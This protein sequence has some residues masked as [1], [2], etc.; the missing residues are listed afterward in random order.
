MAVGEIWCTLG[1]LIRRYLETVLGAGN[2]KIGAFLDICVTVSVI[3][4]QLIPSRKLGLFLHGRS[5]VEWEA[6]RSCELVTVG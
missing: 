5:A 2:L 1:Q 4:F 6:N 3:F